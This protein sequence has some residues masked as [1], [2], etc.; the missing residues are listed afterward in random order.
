[1]P[2]PMPWNER[3]FA[4]DLPLAMFPNVLERLRGAPPRLAERL[5]GLDAAQLARRPGDSWSILENAAHLVQVEAIWIGRLDDFARGVP[6]LR[7]ADSS[8]QHTAAAASGAAVASGAQDA[9]EVAGEIASEFAR[10]RARFVARLEALG[11][12]DLSRTALHPR[13][14]QPMRVLDH[15]LFAAEHDDHHLARIGELRRL[16]AG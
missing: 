2:Q 6:E 7:A 14:R 12:A 5:G 3:R 4:A 1:M 10:A 15:M 8:H 16:L 13:L 9:G 11:E